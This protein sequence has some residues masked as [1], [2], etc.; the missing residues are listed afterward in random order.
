[1][2]GGIIAGWV[3]GCTKVFDN[4]YKR[5]IGIYGAGEL[6]ADHAGDRRPLCFGAQHTWHTSAMCLWVMPAA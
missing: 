1:M 2:L 3:L 6:G 4:Q 5:L